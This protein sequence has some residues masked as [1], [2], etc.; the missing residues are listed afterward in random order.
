MWCYNEL[1]F[2]GSR[3]SWWPCMSTCNR[4]TVTIDLGDHKSSHVWFY[5]LF[6][7]DVFTYSHEK[8]SCYWV[9]ITSFNTRFLPWPKNPEE[10][11]LPVIMCRGMIILAIS[12]D[13]IA[14]QLMN[15]FLHFMNKS[16][17]TLCATNTAWTCTSVT[18]VLY[19][20]ILCMSVL[21]SIQILYLYLICSVDTYS[22]K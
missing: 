4:C 7:G 8:L 12:G 10:W 13:S 14:L 1:L 2:G 16:P 18:P 11:S 20:G 22:S 5:I 17:S 21:T 9:M 19:T 3:T 6:Q 15:A